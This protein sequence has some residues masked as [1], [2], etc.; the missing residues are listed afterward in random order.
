MKHLIKEKPTTNGE[1]GYTDF[2]A[3]YISGQLVGK[4]RELVVKHELSHIWLQHNLRGIKFKKNRKETD[5]TLLNVAMDLEIA[6]HLYD[7][8][9]FKTIKSRYSLVNGGITQE[10]CKK[11]PNCQYFEEYY[12]ELEKEQK[13]NLKSW[14]TANKFDLKDKTKSSQ[15]RE[16]VAQAKEKIR[17]LNKQRSIQKHQLKLREYKIK[18]SLASEID[19]VAGRQKIARIK[20]YRRPNRI[21]SEFFSKG[22]ISIRKTPK[23]TIY[24]DRSGSF[25][26]QKTSEA[27]NTLRKILSKYRGSIINDVL[28][29]NDELMEKDPMIGNGGT[30]HQAVVDEI[31][32]SQS[33]LSIIV[34]D[35]D[36]GLSE[37]PKNLPKTLIIPIGCQHT[38]IA[39]KLGVI[40]VIL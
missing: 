40:E 37:I 38:S 29:F 27:T 17:E 14:D 35:D 19:A 25:D 34:T 16:S 28:Y 32:K 5:H 3:I 10:D 33:E 7:E 13:Q 15:R 30:N 21:E 6:K 18:P 24:I 39:R 9:D 31:V 22:T 4:E 1:I 26:V 20:S 23:I 36:D 2:T 8:H 11:Y 12:L